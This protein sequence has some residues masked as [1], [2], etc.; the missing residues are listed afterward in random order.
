MPG[1]H[2][3]AYKIES[4]LGE[5]GMGAVYRAIDTKLNRPVAIKILADDFADAAARRRFQREAQ[6]ASSLNHPH[7][8][9]VYDAGEHEGRQYLVTEFVDGGTLKDW[10]NAGQ[11]SWRQIVELLTGVA[12]G[13][14]AAHAAGITHRDIKPANILVAKNG[15]AKLADFGLA[16]LQESLDPDATRTLDGGHTRPG[17]V[18]GTIAY[19][20]PE[21][22]S[23]QRLDARSD[24]FS[25]G[26]VLYELLAGHRPFQAKGELELLKTIIEKPAQPLPDRIPAGLSNVVEKALEKDPA[27]RY[28]TARDLVVDLRRAGKQKAAAA[29]AGQPAR[30]TWLPWSVAAVFGVAA[31]LGLFFRGPQPDAGQTSFEIGPPR[32]GEFAFLDN[33]DHDMAISP[34]GREI[35]FRATLNG[36]TRIW[37]RSRGEVAPRALPGTEG[38]YGPFWSPDSLSLG[39]FSGGQLKVVAAAGG[40]VRVAA[41][42]P[43]TANQGTWAPD[44]DILFSDFVAR[45]IFRVSADGGAPTSAVAANAVMNADVLLWPRF[46]PDGKTFLFMSGHNDGEH[47]IWSASLGGGEPK[48]LFKA[49]SR[50]EYV[51][52]GHVLFAMDGALLAQ[53]FDL[54]TM[55][56]EGAPFTVV[57]LIQYFRPTGMAQFSAAGNGALAYRSWGS[58][59]RVAVFDRT[60]REIRGVMPPAAYQ[61]PRVSPDGKRLVVTKFDPR[62]GTEDLYVGD[63]AGGPGSRI[64]SSPG[65]EFGPVWRDNMTIVFTRDNNAAPFLHQIALDGRGTEEALTSPTGQVQLP[66]ARSPDGSIVYQDFE[67]GTNID[68][69]LLP[70]GGKKPEKILASRANE[71]LADVSPDGGWLTYVSDETDGLQVYVRAFSPAQLGP[72]RRISVN[73]GVLPRWSGDGRELYFLERGRL[74]VRSNPRSDAGSVTLLFQPAEGLVDYDVAPD[75]QFL[76]NLGKVGYNVAPITVI[77]GWDQELKK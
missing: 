18:I 57:P 34:D 70:P 27:E 5:G 60:G 48:F 61:S 8:L 54:G 3:A 72:P 67:P 62:T 36:E 4:L 24:I 7:I 44:G 17:A 40:P 43:T 31:V 76:V 71:T 73:G 45:G 38:G 6:M 19:M 13:L 32:G 49:K 21:Q 9:T 14:A 28:Q 11:R 46:L 77:L 55:Q 33:P 50:T 65:D 66:T 74:M 47:E 41:Q 69:W 58:A 26:V 15:Y 56:L 63:L 20:S 51:P 75:G 25:L 64:T 10:A 22:A 23:G 39:F 1:A 29:S 35:A 68:L 53:Q 30:R 2:I 16:K 59:S 52:T 42:V 12:D 37:I